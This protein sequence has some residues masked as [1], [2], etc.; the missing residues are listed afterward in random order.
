MKKPIHKYNG[1]MGATL[2]N[3]CRVIINTGLTEDVYC[4]DCADNKVVYHNRYRDK[5]IFEHIGNEVTM[6]G[7][8]WIRYG[9]A[10][11]DSI[12]MVDPS[13]GPYIEIGNNLNHFW[14]R[15]EYQ[16]LIIESITLRNGEG[17]T[18]DVVFKIK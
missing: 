17:D 7:G 1:G 11:D 6:K 18:M 15:D 2:C 4:K 8:S 14:P 9:I 12:N 13:G 10:D 16:D 3:N 5:I